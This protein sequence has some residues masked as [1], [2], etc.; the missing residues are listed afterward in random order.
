[1]RVRFNVDYHRVPITDECS[2]EEKVC[3]KLIQ[4]MRTVRR[5]DGVVFNCQLGRGRTT[6]G[7]VIACILWRCITGMP[8]V[9]HWLVDGS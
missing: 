4:I 7:M 9:A 2:P 8:Q 3:E 1:M 6:T 5:C